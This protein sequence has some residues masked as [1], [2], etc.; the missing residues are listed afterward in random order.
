MTAASPTRVAR[1]RARGEIPFASR[2]AVG[3]QLAA[4]VATVAAAATALTAAFAE[5]LR[6]ATRAAAS[7]D[8][9]VSSQALS[10]ALLGAGRAA[11][12]G[13]L[14]GALALALAHT[15][16]TRFLLLWPTRATAPRGTEATLAAAWGAAVLAAGLLGAAGALRGRLHAGSPTALAEGLAA[17]GEGLGGWVAGAALLLGAAELVWRRKRFLQAMTPTRAEAERERR[18]SEGAPEVRDA[19]RRAQ[20]EA[21]EGLDA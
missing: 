13:L 21:T 6:V 11:G 20:A 12:P 10:A 1:A 19:R 17:L 4:I 16:Q 15:A 7:P 18:E 3:A 14:A 9:A 8:P 2:L 5:G